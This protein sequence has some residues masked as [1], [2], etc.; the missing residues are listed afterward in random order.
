LGG[1]RLSTVSGTGTLRRDLHV[2]LFKGFSPGSD[3]QL[4]THPPLLLLLHATNSSVQ[5][6]YRSDPCA[7]VLFSISLSLSPIHE[8]YDCAETQR[9]SKPRSCGVWRVVP[10]HGQHRKSARRPRAALY[11]RP[12]S[13][14]VFRRCHSVIL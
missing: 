9:L 1:R 4:H 7:C 10:H 8:F 3:T 12:E 11:Q 13:L 5:V 2:C 14:Y 6:L